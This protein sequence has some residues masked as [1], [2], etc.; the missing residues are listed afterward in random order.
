MVGFL[1]RW[2]AAFVL[3]GLTYNPTAWNFIRWSRDNW[4]GQLPIITLLGVLLV[5]AYVIYLRG[6]AVA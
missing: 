5:I 1:I 6:L 2:A 3:L 4:E